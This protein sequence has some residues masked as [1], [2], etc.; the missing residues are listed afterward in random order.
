MSER[1]TVSELSHEYGISERTLRDRIRK[2]CFSHRLRPNGVREYELTDDF[3]KKVLSIH[4][5]FKNL[6]KA[7]ERGMSV[8]IPVEFSKSD[9]GGL[10]VTVGPDDVRRFVNFLRSFGDK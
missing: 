3:K 4:P 1:K 2:G 9:N 5:R 10:C 6:K 8:R 7:A